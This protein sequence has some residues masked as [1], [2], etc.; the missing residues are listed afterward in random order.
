MPSPSKDFN[1]MRLEDIPPKLPATWSAHLFH[2]FIS[3]GLVAAALTKREGDPKK[4]YSSLR[5]A[6]K[7]HFDNQ[8][9]VIKRDD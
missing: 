2:D 1:E 7:N 3:S 5:T 4:I 6:S 8:V 9:A